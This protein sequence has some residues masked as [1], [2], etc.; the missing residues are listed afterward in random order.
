MDI[1]NPSF[2]NHIDI[3]NHTLKEIGADNIPVIYVYNKIDLLDIAD[4]ENGVCISAKNNIGIDELIEKI[5]KNIF[6]DYVNCK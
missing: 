3:T 1:S 4:R 5:S 2:E 6:S